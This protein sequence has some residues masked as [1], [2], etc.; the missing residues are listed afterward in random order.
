MKTA[1]SNSDM[2]EARSRIAMQ[3]RAGGTE[4]TSHAPCLW[5]GRIPAGRQVGVG[6]GAGWVSLRAVG[7]FDFKDSGATVMEMWTVCQAGLECLPRTV[8]ECM[9]DSRATRQIRT[10][11]AN[12][13]RRLARSMLAIPPDSCGCHTLT[14]DDPGARVEADLCR[15]RMQHDLRINACKS[16]PINL[17]SATKSRS[18]TSD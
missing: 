18:T 11:G 4:C 12:E 14:T 13:R 17:V 3:S 10:D 7:R 5:T 1:I 2:K 8:G 16:R 6:V 9:V 15:S